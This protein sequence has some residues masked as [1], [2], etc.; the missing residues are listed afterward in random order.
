M[1]FTYDVRVFYGRRAR[2][3]MADKERFRTSKA[4]RGRARTVQNGPGNAVLE[5]RLNMRRE[6]AWSNIQV[7]IRVAKH[8]PAF[9]SPRSRIPD[10]RAGRSP[11]NTRQT[12]R[13][14]GASP[15][16]RGVQIRATIP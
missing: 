12:A 1:F 6:N 14:V 7:F 3:G 10:R 9:R 5:T 15:R 11:N 4:A 2:P 16:S 13:R 8:E